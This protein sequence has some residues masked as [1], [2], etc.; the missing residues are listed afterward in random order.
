[1][2]STTSWRAL[3]GLAAALSIAPTAAVACSVC[4]CG[5]PLLISSDPAAITGTLRLQLDAEFLGMTAGSEGMPGMTDE[6]RQ[7]SVRLNAVYRPLD[8]LSFSAT[9]PWTSKTMRMLGGSAPVTTS[10]LSGLGDVEV[11]ARWA[12]W[13]RVNLGTGVVHELALSGGGSLPTGSNGTLDPAGVRVDEHGQLGSGSWGPFLGA[14]YRFEAGRWVAAA[15]LSG[16]THTANDA[17]YT[18]GAALLWSA[19][20]QYQPARW[21]ALDLGVDGRVARADKDNGATVDNTGG[22]VVSAAPGVY[23]NP[24]GGLWVF[25]RGQVPFHQALLGEQ[26]VRPS[27]A[28]GLQYSLL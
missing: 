27:V 25:A 28:V 10:D 13:R 4:G 12:A 18:Y 19:H 7:R 1:M 26:Q 24:T 21:I 8:T 14:S 16:R 3:A 9:L 2:P 22:T 15:S 23:V 17:G 5:D 6:L 20:G 11:G